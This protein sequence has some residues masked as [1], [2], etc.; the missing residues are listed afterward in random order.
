[1]K[2]DILTYFAAV[3]FITIYLLKGIATVLPALLTDTGS[4]SILTALMDQETENN[5]NNT[6]ERF[7]TETKE[8]YLHHNFLISVVIPG[9]ANSQK[10]IEENNIAFKQH[11]YASI[12]TPPPE[13]A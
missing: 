6:E 4:K 8:L 13:Q 12:P 11:V 1:M 9:V 3:F 5:K 7:D 10:N 2:K